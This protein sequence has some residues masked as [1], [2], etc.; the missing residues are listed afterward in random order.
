M[1]TAPPF[2]ARRSGP[3]RWTAPEALVQRKFS[4][5]SD[6]WAFGVTC[7]EVWADGAT[8][9]RQWTNAIVMEEVLQEF[10]L[11]KPKGCPAK[12]YAKVMIPTLMFDKN[13]R[14]K[15]AALLPIVE[16][17]VEHDGGTDAEHVL[18]SSGSS[19]GSS[20]YDDNSDGSSDDSLGM[21]SSASATD[22]DD[23]EE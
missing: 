6:V 13:D 23:G 21:S 1:G 15:F 9:Y 8:P 5:A 20:S 22:S 4:E 17:L 2:L 14:P 18:P 3:G 16:E 11:P 12:F 7:W 19:A 10:V